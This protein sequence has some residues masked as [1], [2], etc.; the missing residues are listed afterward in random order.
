MTATLHRGLSPVRTVLGNG[1]TVLVQP[2]TTHR[3]VT[4][5]VSVAAGSGFDPPNQI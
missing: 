3:A 1:A 5:L 4:L 2:T